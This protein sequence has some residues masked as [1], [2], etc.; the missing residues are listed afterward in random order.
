MTR[1]I[2]WLD[3]QIRT[4]GLIVWI[5]EMDGLDLTKWFA[6]VIRYGSWVD[7]KNDY[8]YYDW[9]MDKTDQTVKMEGWMDSNENTAPSAQKVEL[10]RASNPLALGPFCN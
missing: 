8:M 7:W 4:D 9:L 1:R 6:Q 5:D 10:H 3:E 2:D